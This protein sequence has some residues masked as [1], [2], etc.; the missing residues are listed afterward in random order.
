LISLP[1]TVTI[2]GQ[3][4]TVMYQGAAP[5]LVAGMSQINVQVPAGVTPGSAVS[6]TITVGGVASVNTVTMAVK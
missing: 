5:G 2:G 6:V 4:A 1:V 3:S